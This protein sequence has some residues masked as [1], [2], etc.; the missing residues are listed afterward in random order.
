VAAA[1]EATITVRL[2]PRAGA[3]RI[4]GIETDPQGRRVLKVAVTAA[5]VDGA[6]N[7]A[8]IRLLAKRLGLPKSAVTLLSGAGAR[9]KRLAFAGDA[10][11]IAAR[12]AALERGAP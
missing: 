7:A 9:V 11:D 1:P 12:L 5:P 10:A 3:D 6:A 2:T 8:L 4:I